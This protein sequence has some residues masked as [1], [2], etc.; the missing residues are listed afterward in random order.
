MPPRQ[1]DIY[2]IKA[3]NAF[4]GWPV[5]TEREILADDQ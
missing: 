1:A 5:V 3:K 4:N 2:F